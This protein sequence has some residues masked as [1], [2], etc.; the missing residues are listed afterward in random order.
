MKHEEMLQIKKER[1]K[2]QGSL[3]G[4]K[5]QI[6]EKNKEKT[7]RVKEALKQ[8][9]EKINTYWE[10]RKL[11]YADMHTQKIVENDKMRA[12]KEREYNE[13]ESLEMEL[14]RKLEHSQNLHE[15]VSRELESV[16]FLPPEEFMN[17]YGQ[18]RD[19]S[20]FEEKTK[21]KVLN[22]KQSKV[23]KPY[24][25]KKGEAGGKFGQDVEINLQE[26]S[27]DMLDRTDRNNSVSKSYGLDQ[28]QE[29][30]KVENSSLLSNSK[31]PLGEPITDR[32]QGKVDGNLQG[33]GFNNKEQSEGVLEQQNEKANENSPKNQS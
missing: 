26:S 28:P 6:V 11:Q 22:N 24:I 4:F 18:K 13:L 3:M 30:E 17:K 5:N 21:R 7:Q 27:I 29:F 1:E 31:N 8:S 2:N 9:H 15:N 10:R 20:L 25:A 14:L 32:D 12:K 19:E 23:V 16:L 33:E